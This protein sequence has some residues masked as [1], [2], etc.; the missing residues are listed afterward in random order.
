MRKFSI[1]I[2][3]P[4]LIFCS[5]QAQAG[6]VLSETEVTNAF[7]SS[8]TLDRTI[9]VQ[10]KKQKIETKDG[11]IIIDLDK[12][13]IYRVNPSVKSYAEIALNDEASL[14]AEADLASF[15]LRRTGVTRAIGGY[16]CEEYRGSQKVGMMDLTISM[17]MS[18]DI[19]GAAEITAFQDELFSRFTGS[20]SPTIP[21]SLPLERRSTIKPRTFRKSPEGQPSKSPR[22]MTTDTLLKRIQVKNLPASTFQPPIGFHR[23][24]PDSA[25]TQQ[26]V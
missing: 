26:S 10:G 17:C 11:Q 7:G 1:L 21:S 9:Y 3:P 22:A 18:K 19:P 8:V 2:V 16:S 15:D 24:Q 6:V 20:P 12:G 4:A 5:H 13:V 23:Q 14:A 25:E